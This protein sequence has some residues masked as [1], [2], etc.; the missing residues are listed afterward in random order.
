MSEAK[1]KDKG[2]VISFAQKF[3][4]R[5]GHELEVSPEL[6]NQDEPISPEK[7][8][9]V[10]I[11]IELLDIVSKSSTEQPITT[12]AALQLV[13]TTVGMDLIRRYGHEQAS[14][15]ANTALARSKKYA[16]VFRE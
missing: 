9:V 7:D 4:E 13:G 3:F 8:P 10:R 14:K 2:Q 15:I 11:A 5:H 16:P 6:E 1:E 12:M